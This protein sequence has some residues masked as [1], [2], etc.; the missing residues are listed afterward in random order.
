MIKLTEMQLAV[1]RA[2]PGGVDAKGDNGASWAEVAELAAE[3]GLTKDQVKGVLSGLGKRG[4]VQFDEK[5][6]GAAGKIQCLTDE[7]CDAIYAYAVP[8]E[9]SNH[10]EPA[11]EE[12]LSLIHI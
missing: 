2:F 3:S 5:P 10:D 12:A 1:L 9:F 8:V 6:N 4:L 11:A 7:G